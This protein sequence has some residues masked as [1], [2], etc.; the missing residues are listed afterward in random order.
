MQLS[1]FRYRDVKGR[2]P[3]CLFT[4]RDGNSIYHQCYSGLV[5]AHR[6]FYRNREIKH[7]IQTLP[8]Q[9]GD[10]G[11]ADTRLKKLCELSGVSAA[12]QERSVAEALCGL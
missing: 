2:V 5:A 4:I 11:V 1:V 10:I 6:T 7:F 3:E 9:A 12:R 8:C